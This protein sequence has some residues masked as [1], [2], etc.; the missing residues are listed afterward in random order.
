M[1]S[2]EGG[3]R[4]ASMSRRVA[5]SRGYQNEKTSSVVVKAGV[6]AVFDGVLNGGEVVVEDELS[7]EEEEVE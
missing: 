1:L 7:E 4:S 2:E 3:I 5:R 6:L